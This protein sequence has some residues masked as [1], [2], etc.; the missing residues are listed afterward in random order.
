MFE[1]AEIRW[2]WPQQNLSLVHSWFFAG[3]QRV[4]QEKRTDRYLVFPKCSSTGVKLRE[5]RFEI[6]V[7]GETV[8]PC[9]L[10]KGVEGQVEFW[11]KWSH[12]N[13]WPPAKLKNLHR[14][15]SWQIVS[16]HRLL[17]RFSAKGKE[18]ASEIHELESGCQVELGQVTTSSEASSWLTLGLEAFGADADLEEILTKVAADFFLGHGQPPG[19]KLTPDKSFGYPG[20]LSNVGKKS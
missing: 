13:F 2:F 11:R 18:I 19:V 5:E 3:G 20:W 16:K 4:S 14:S 6:K 9:P 7:R 12:D 10:P 17:R 15:D 8:K 1:T